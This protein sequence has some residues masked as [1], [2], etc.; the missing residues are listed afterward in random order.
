[1]RAASAV[2]ELALPAGRRSVTDVARARTKGTATG[3]AAPPATSPG[4]KDVKATKPP[5]S[6]SEASTTPVVLAC[7]AVVTST[8]EVVPAPRSRT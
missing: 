8:K 7:P 5:S 6:A 3:E 4:A 1:M 2:N